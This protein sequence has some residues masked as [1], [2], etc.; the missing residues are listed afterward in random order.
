MKM[1]SLSGDRPRRPSG[2]H[3][4]GPYYNWTAGDLDRHRIRPTH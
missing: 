1:D 3:R 4:G 2:N